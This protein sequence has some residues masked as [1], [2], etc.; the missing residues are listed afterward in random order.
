[1]RRASMALAAI[2]LAVL[3]MAA[4]HVAPAFAANGTTVVLSASTTTPAPGDQVTLTV[5]ATNPNGLAAGTFSIS[6]PSGTL[7]S[8]L[9]PTSSTSTSATVTYTWPFP[10]GETDVTAAYGVGFVKTSS[11]TVAIIAGSAPAPTSTVTLSATPLS[12]GQGDTVSFSVNVAGANGSG[13]PTG[14]VTLWDS[15]NGAAAVAVA[16]L[17]LD[18]SGNATQQQGGFG[19]GSHVFTATY[20]GDGTF[21][22][23]SSNAVTLQIT[24]TQSL[25]QTTITASASPNPVPAGGVTTLS[26]HVV[27][28]GNATIVANGGNVTFRN[29]DNNALIAEAPLDSSGTASVDVGGWA[30]GQYS[31]IALYVGSTTYASSSQTITLAAAAANVTVTGP[32]LTTTYGTIPTVLTPTYSGGASPQTPAQ[33][34]TAAT[35]TSAPGTY[36]ITC[37]GASDPSYSFSYVA[38]QLTIAPA[39]LTISP[40]GATMVAGDPVPALTPTIT[41]FVNGESL[42]HSDVTGAATCT[43]TATS[44]SAPG[45]YPITCTAGTLASTDYQFAVAGSA[46][47]TVQAATPVTVTAPSV[48]F[49]Y[50]GT[51][52]ALTPTYSPAN[53]TLTTQ[54][55][56]TTTATSSSPV[57]TYPVTCSGAAGHGYTFTYVA[58]S[59][60]ITPATLTVNAPNATMTAGSAVPTLTPTLTGFVNG[61]TQ[62]SAVTGAATCTTTATSSSAAGTY[63]ITCTVGTLAAANYTFVVGPAGTLTV[64]PN[65]PTTL[66]DWVAGPIAVGRPVLLSATLL[67]GFF[68]VANEP[69][70]LTLG[71]A[72]CTATTSFLGTAT[73]W[74]TPTGPLGPTTSTATFA[75][76]STYAA[77]SDTNSVLLYAFVNGGNDGCGFVLGDRS[78]SGH[79]TFWGS[80]WSRSNSFSRGSA[81]S[82]FKGWAGDRSGS[83]WSGSARDT[84]PSSLPS[85]IAVFVANAAGRHGASF[86]GDVSGMVIV[87]VDPGYSASGTGTGTVVGTL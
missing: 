69:I 4:G 67:H 47:V 41:G 33:C 71:S 81:P 25:V 19:G 11:N 40:V 9:A 84:P 62:A 86:S 2:L 15:L 3:C 78:A 44:S 42:S 53:P 34:T 59:V 35:A 14:A 79:V 57:G 48:S 38:G 8:G 64:N 24:P 45:S 76:D 30:P 83:R 10:A 23:A 77:S 26:A 20:S 49:V 61:D 6:T 80:D 37:S 16:T 75:G 82:G 60:T 43:T 68:P 74:V 58:G 87:K 70:V 39:T 28:T 1:M 85:Y 36:A 12:T 52:P 18:S 55:T 65:K 21:P 50:G 29:A 7:V 5:T 63:P 17:T 13:N 27:Q 73:C 32:S 31:I 22:S 66:I 46:N 56:C 51:L 72:S 54:A